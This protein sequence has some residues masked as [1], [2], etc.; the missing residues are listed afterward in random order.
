MLYYFKREKLLWEGSLSIECGYED[1]PYFTLHL[2]RNG[3]GYAI[4]SDGCA[5]TYFSPN[6][7]GAF[8][9]NKNY[10]LSFVE[11][12]PKNLSQVLGAEI[13][14]KCL[15]LKMKY[16]GKEKGI[17]FYRFGT[18]NVDNF[19]FK[20]EYTENTLANSEYLLAFYKDYI[21]LFNCSGEVL[22]IKGTFNEVYLAG[23]GFA[24]VK[25]RENEVYITLLTV[26]EKP[27]VRF[28]RAVLWK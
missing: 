10:C 14:T 2:S 1:Y 18:Y 20:A 22:R 6:M 12:P 27:E 23:E 16:K 8:L 11:G 28:I 15:V 5:V 4:S 13:L 3:F 26:E 24:L 17:Y 7:W 9:P 25:Y 21:A 19:T